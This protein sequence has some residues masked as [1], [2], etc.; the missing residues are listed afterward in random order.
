MAT[1]A[2]HFKTFLSLFKGNEILLSSC[3]NGGTSGSGGKKK[4]T[5]IIISLLTQ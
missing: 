5:K 4:K 2:W 3:L 1:V